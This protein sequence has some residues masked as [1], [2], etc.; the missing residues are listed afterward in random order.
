MENSSWP[1]LYLN[2]KPKCPTAVWSCTCDQDVQASFAF[3]ITIIQSPTAAGS[4]QGFWERA[5]H[6]PQ[7]SYF[8]LWCAD[9]QNPQGVRH[10][11]FRVCS[12]ASLLW[13]LLNLRPHGDVDD[14][15]DFDQ[16]S[17]K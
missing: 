4:H 14:Q 1:Q 9:S 11:F 7:T 15:L 2:I 3:L 13:N 8:C 6:G 17:L 16:Q 5:G 10:L 12:D